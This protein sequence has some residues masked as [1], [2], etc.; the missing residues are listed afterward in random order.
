[1]IQQVLLGRFITCWNINITFSN[2]EG[3]EG[4]NGSQP[5]SWLAPG[6]PYLDLA[7]RRNARSVTKASARCDGKEKNEKERLSLSSSF[8]LLTALPLTVFLSGSLRNDQGRVNLLPTLSSQ[9]TYFVVNFS[10]SHFEYFKSPELRIWVS[11]KSKATGSWFDNVALTTCRFSARSK[12]KEMR[13]SRSRDL[14]RKERW[15]NTDL[16]CIN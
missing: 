7:E 5:V 15:M 14:V 2:V 16:L 1:M 13:R 8:P 11:V 9:I 3:R 12:L 6:C 10:S 4:K